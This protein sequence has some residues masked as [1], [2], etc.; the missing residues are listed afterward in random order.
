MILP[1]FFTL[2]IIVFLS[3]G[4]KVLKLITYT[5]IFNSFFIFYAAYNHTP[6]CLENVTIVTSFPYFSIFAFPIGIKN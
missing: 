2:S 5:S 1:V 3:K 4:L 6:T